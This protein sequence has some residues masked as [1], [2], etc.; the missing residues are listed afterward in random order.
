MTTCKPT[1]FYSPIQTTVP[2]GSARFSGTRRVQATNRIYFGETS[3]GFDIDDLAAIKKLMARYHYGKDLEQLMAPETRFKAFPDKGGVILR[4]F[5]FPGPPNQASDKGVCHE[6]SAALIRKLQALFKDKYQ[7]ITVVG[8]AKRFF[9]DPQKTD[10]VFIMG[11]TPQNIA[12]LED[13]LQERPCRPHAETSVF[14]PTFNVMADNPDIDSYRVVSL[15]KGGAPHPD[16]NEYQALRFDKNGITSASPLGYS[17]ELGLNLRNTG[18]MTL[19]YLSFQKTQ[20]GR[21]LPV[22][23]LQEETN[24]SV[25]LYSNWRDEVSPNS[26]LIPLMDKL[27]RDLAQPD[28][29]ELAEINR[30]RKGLDFFRLK[31]ETSSTDDSKG[32]TV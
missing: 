22:L 30:Q 8:S 16:E 5:D 18:K 32:K 21:V 10:H 6:L 31:R 28:E 14:D 17:E 2:S 13:K 7:F 19:V 25:Y 29:A 23:A 9:F 24:A 1:G 26:P 3:H 20:D 27:E 4:N 11:G 15:H 12:R